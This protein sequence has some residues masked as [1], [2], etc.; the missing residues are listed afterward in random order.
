MPLCHRCNADRLFSLLV[1]VRYNL[2]SRVQQYLLKK[3]T[4]R[5]I[6]R[7]CEVHSQ[8]SSN[9]THSVIIFNKV[10]KNR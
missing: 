3:K 5:E 10:V 2:L 8:Y 1:T 4:W 6:A 7:M 9:G